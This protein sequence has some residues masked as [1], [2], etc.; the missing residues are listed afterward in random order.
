MQI[1]T[2][3]YVFYQV[4]PLGVVRS[5]VLGAVALVSCAGM[6]LKMKIT[7]KQSSRVTKKLPRI[8]FSERWQVPPLTVA[9]FATMPSIRLTRTFVD[10]VNNHLLTAGENFNLVLQAVRTR[11]ANA[12]FFKWLGS[13]KWN[14]P[15]RRLTEAD[16]KNAA[17]SKLLSRKI[18][19]RVCSKRVRNI[20]IDGRSVLSED[21]GRPREGV[22]CSP[23]FNLFLVCVDLCVPTLHRWGLP[24]HWDRIEP[25]APQLQ[26]V[27]SDRRLLDAGVACQAHHQRP[28]LTRPIV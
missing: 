13:A 8:L 9:G 18:F 4:R 20:D 21:A 24:I 3:G 11:Q 5:A 10:A 2:C 6:R 15:L 25:G 22:K 23:E 27:S 14:S 19:N 26:S 1:A 12:G 7:F 16:Q 17:V 28:H